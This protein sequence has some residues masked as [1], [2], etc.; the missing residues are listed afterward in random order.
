MGWYTEWREFKSREIE[1]TCGCGKQHHVIPDDAKENEQGS[2]W[3]CVCGSTLF[4]PNPETKKQIDESR[5]KKA[6]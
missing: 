1:K 3:N 6:A 5:N 4:W 2:F